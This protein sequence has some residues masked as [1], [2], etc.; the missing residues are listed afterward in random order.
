MKLLAGQLTEPGRVVDVGAMDVNGSYR[1]LFDGW[2]YVGVDI[3]EGKNVDIVMTDE[4]SIPLPDKWA[5]LVISGQCIEHVRNP[6]KLVA[7]MARI[8]SGALILV[9]PHHQRIHRYPIDTFRYN[10]DGM[11]ALIEEAGLICADAFLG[12]AQP[13]IRDCWG[14]G[15][16]K[17][18]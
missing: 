12:P 5:D 7:E 4:Y 6:F 8:L 11:R 2:E 16:A 18:S 13:N 1:P 3:A 17:R 9:A 15:Y 14:I 10:P